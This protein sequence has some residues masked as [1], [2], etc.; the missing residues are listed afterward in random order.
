[1]STSQSS[2]SEYP[3]FKT[4]PANPAPVVDSACLASCLAQYAAGDALDFTKRKGALGCA[5][6]NAADAAKEAT[7]AAFKAAKAVEAYLAA[8]EYTKTLE[9]IGTSHTWKAAVSTRRALTSVEHALEVAGATGEDPVM[10]AARAAV[11][12]IPPLGDSVKGDWHSAMAAW[13][14]AHQAWKVVAA[15]T[16]AAEE[17]D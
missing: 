17:A 7:D 2:M 1:M 10:A 3:P 12:T 13:L 15:A 8:A 4:L 16:L 14:R 5:S 6:Q 9:Y 11:D